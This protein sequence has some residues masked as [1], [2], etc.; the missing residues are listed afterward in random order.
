MA[1][2]TIAAILYVMTLV[3]VCIWVFQDAERRGK[4]G[5]LAGL[6]VFFLG[7]PGGLLAWLLFRPELPDQT[8]SPSK[9]TKPWPQS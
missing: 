1:P 3:G 7:F 6:M 9:E 8:Q 5:W 2:A 4:S